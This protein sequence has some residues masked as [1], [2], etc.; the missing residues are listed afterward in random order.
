M[1]CFQRERERARER[2]N[3]R[4]KERERFRD[5][6]MCLECVYMYLLAQIETY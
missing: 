5:D 6:N 3:E 2:E 4:K 1:S